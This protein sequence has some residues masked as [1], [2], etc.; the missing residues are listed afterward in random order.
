MLILKG[1][2]FEA[3]EIH[4]SSE[5]HL[6]LLTNVQQL[7]SHVLVTP[8]FDHLAYSTAGGVSLPA[9]QAQFLIVQIVGYIHANNHH[10]N[11]PEKV[12]NIVD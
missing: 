11:L 7:E 12:F 10:Q 2:A 6:Y 1:I 9:L 4:I 3:A 5:K 8:N